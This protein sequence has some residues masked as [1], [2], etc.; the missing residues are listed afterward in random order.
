MSMS[1]P[2]GI[3]V[4]HIG[5]L[6][7]RD[8]FRAVRPL[9]AFMTESFGAPDEQLAEFR[10]LPDAVND[11]ERRARMLY[12]L[13]NSKD[14]RGADQTAYVVATNSPVLGEFEEVVGVGIL[15]RSRGPVISIDHLRVAPLYRRQG[16]G[17][18]IVRTALETLGIHGPDQ[19]SME[20]SGSNGAGAYFLGR[21]GMTYADAHMSP[22]TAE[23][24]GFSGHQLE[25]RQLVGLPP[26]A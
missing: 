2:E 16:V 8:A 6:R 13:T 20:I 15:S 1:A 9:L 5:R 24:V 3:T 7:P 10:G 19:L 26:T 14:L 21:I 4:S 23:P 22:L 17:T 11:A 18:E 25:V 12:S